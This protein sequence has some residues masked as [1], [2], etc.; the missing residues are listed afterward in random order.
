MINKYATGIRAGF[1]SLTEAVMVGSWWQT[2][3]TCDSGPRTLSRHISRVYAEAERKH[4]PPLTLIPAPTVVF[5]GR[6]SGG[7]VVG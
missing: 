3:P 2:G 5:A 4:F 1:S 6:G 7:W